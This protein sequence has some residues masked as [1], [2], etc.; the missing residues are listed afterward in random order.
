MQSNTKKAFLT[1]QVQ[2][3][4][5]WPSFGTCSFLYIDLLEKTT[6]LKSSSVVSFK[7]MVYYRVKDHIII[8]FEQSYK[9]NGP[10]CNLGKV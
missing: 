8:F 2:S 1:N 4:Y 7:A 10:N 5:P 9:F 6:E 3:F